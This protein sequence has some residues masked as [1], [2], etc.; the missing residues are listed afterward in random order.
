MQYSS[1]KKQKKD[2]DSVFCSFRWKINRIRDDFIESAVGIQN[3]KVS[4]FISTQRHRNQ[5]INT[6]HL[7]YQL[8]IITF[9][10]APGIVVSELHAMTLTFCVALLAFGPGSAATLL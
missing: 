4:L 8:K 7:L 10:R 3:T 1:L 2:I 9:C 5:S 6:Q